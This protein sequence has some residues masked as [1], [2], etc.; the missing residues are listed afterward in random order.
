MIPF[1]TEIY[2]K[3]KVFDYPM[4]PAFRKMLILCKVPMPRLF[5]EFSANI[6][7]YG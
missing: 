3:V 1:T 4:L 5:V 2:Q 7:V 6:N